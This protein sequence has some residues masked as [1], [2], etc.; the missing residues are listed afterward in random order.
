MGVNAVVVINCWDLGLLFL[1]SVV[2]GVSRGE[3]LGQIWVQC[4]PWVQDAAP[5][6]RAGAGGSLHC[7]GL[8]WGLCVPRA[9]PCAVSPLLWVGCVLPLCLEWLPWPGRPGMQRCSVSGLPCCA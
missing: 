5:P 7:E 2:L 4:G 8:L 6:A 9:L 1:V 3:L